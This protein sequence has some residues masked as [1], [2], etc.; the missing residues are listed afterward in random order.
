MKTAVNNGLNCM[1][2]SYV[3]FLKYK[4]I[5]PKIWST[6]QYEGFDKGDYKSQDMWKYA[7][8]EISEKDS[9]DLRAFEYPAIEKYM[10][11]RKEINKMFEGKFIGIVNYDDGNIYIV[12]HSDDLVKN[13]KKERVEKLRKRGIDKKLDYENGE[14][15]KYCEN[16][17]IN[18]TKNL[19]TSFPFLHEELM[20]LYNIGLNDR[21]LSMKIRRKFPEIN[22]GTNKIL[23]WRKI[24]NL[25]ANKTIGNIC[26]IDGRVENGFLDLYNL[27][28]NDLEIGITL[29]IH[30]G[31]ITAWR[32]R[33]NLKANRKRSKKK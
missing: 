16:N 28:L 27:G 7:K 15:N 23:R 21:Y 6:I 25:P 10:T 18:L 32:F 14:S 24:N 20:R 12:A 1:N 17:I 3:P 11:F 31:K 2:L 30:P 8:Y 22:F 29:G 9:A 4:K 5:I 13:E 26:K 33:N 19:L